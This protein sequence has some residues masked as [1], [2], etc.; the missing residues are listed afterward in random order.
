M[1]GELSVLALAFV[2]VLVMMGALWL[3]RA[4]RRSA[5]T[6]EARAVAEELLPEIRALMESAD[7]KGASDGEPAV[8]HHYEAYRQRLPQVFTKEHIFA[9]ETFYQCV[10]SY[11]EAR[12]FMN[13]AF[14]GEIAPSLGDR[15]RAKDLRDRCLKDVYYTG[16]AAVQTLERVIR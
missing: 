3:V 6:R 15:I 7:P 12:S 11:R 16:D 4:R 5:R 13:D 10:E 9:L 1:P 8:A 2:G 14:A